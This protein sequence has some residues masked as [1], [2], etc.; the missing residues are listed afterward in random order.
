[1]K[2]KSYF[3]FNFLL[4]AALLLSTSIFAQ[5]DYTSRVVNSSFE[6]NDLGETHTGGVLRVIEPFGW[7]FNHNF[8]INTGV[9]PD[10]V[11]LG[12]NSQGLNNDTGNRDGNYNFWFSGQN[13]NLPDFVELSQT[14][15]PEE[16]DYLPAGRYLVSCRME[17]IT[18][19]ITTQRLFAND[20]VQYF[21]A[22]ADYDLNL[23]PGEINS[24]AGHAVSTGNP[25]TMKDLEVIITL[26]ETPLLK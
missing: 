5:V 7:S 14:I 25:G 17:I 12:N 1:M 24:Y 15:I 4:A 18:D 21:G 26:M 6:L 3:I 10:V 19:K 2:R 11:Y 13:M 23:T 20:L 8:A 22:E 9:E 16:G